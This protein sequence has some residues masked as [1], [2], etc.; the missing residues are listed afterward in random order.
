M[1][2]TLTVFDESTGGTRDEVLELT[3]PTEEITVRDL[4]R[5][6]V[7]QEV[8]D[9]N[10]R[11]ASGSLFRGLVQP[12]DAEATLNGYKLKKP[13]MIDWQPQFDLAI[14]A[15]ET[16]QILLLVDDR[17]AES[18]EQTITIGTRTEVTFLKLTPLVGG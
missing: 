16:N 17:Q 1:P 13:R 4:I 7:H 3:F 6:R 11:S 8:K 14:E 15:F 12:T 5:E 10:A 2:A 18:L 9:H